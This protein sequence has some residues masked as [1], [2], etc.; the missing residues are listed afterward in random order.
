MS[1]VVAPK[2]S[3]AAATLGAV[4]TSKPCPAKKRSM[5]SRTADSSS[6]IRRRPS[7]MRV[8]PVPSQ[9]KDD[10]ERRAAAGPVPGGQRAAVGLDQALRDREAEARAASATAE[11]RLEDALQVGGGQA[12]AF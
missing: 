7:G 4:A 10:G 6:T 12:R 2:D 9:R 8:S 5:G 1:G 3:I 11:E